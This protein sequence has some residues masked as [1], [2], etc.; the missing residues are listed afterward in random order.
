MEKID[1][2]SVTVNVA[3]V[4]LRI[5]ETVTIKATVLPEDATDKTL[6]WTSSDPSVAKVEEGEIT[7][8]KLG[9]AEI[10]A[11]AGDKT[12]S[13][14]VTVEPTPV[15][16]V[17]LDKAN[18]TL[19]VGG[20]TT[21]QATVGPEDATDKTLSWTSSDPS[22]AKVEEGEITALKLGTAEITAKAGDKTASCRVTVEPTPVA[23]V[24]LDKANVTLKVGGKTTL[25]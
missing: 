23:S 11:K 13:C 9:T 24:T 8:L 20:K 22:V 14:R 5:G 7:A 25:Q 2:K 4:T 10:T 16:S 21:L 19:K 1:V 6:S 15:A 18:V 3:T 17:T 12:A